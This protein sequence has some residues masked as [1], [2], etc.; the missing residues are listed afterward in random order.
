VVGEILSGREAR[1]SFLKHKDMSKKSVAQF[2][3]KHTTGTRTV[4]VTANPPRRQP[5]VPTPFVYSADKPWGWLVY[6]DGKFAG[7]ELALKHAVVSIGREEDNEVWLDDD[8]ISRYHAELAWENGQVYVTD[9]DSLNGVLLNGKRIRSSTPV[10]HNDTLEIGDHRFVFRYAQQTST[11]DLD[12]PLLPQLRRVAAARNAAGDSSGR[13]VGDRSL[14]RPTVG[15]DQRH[16]LAS[17]PSTQ[18]G[19]I[20]A[21]ETMVMPRSTPL[22]PPETPAQSDAPLNL[23]LHL[24][25][26]SRRQP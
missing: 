22:P 15:L 1:R 26:P 11:D 6:R 13:S 17:Q 4:A 3:R 25:L 9:A 12:D 10:K 23:P 14:A 16:E 20:A 18:G 7:Q 2:F 5:G 21:Q 8:T 24:R 19:D